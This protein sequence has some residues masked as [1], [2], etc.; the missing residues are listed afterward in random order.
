MEVARKTVEDQPQKRVADFLPLTPTNTK[1]FVE[2]FSSSITAQAMRFRLHQDLIQDVVQETLIRALRGL[3]GFRG[4]SKLSTWVYR[5]AY[6]E[7]L[8]VKERHQ[9]HQGKVASLDTTFEPV[10]SS[11]ES[12]MITGQEDEVLRVQRFMQQLPDN[13]RLAMGYH[14]MDE[15][16]VS[17]IA[18]LMGST[19]NTVK[20]WLKRGR[21]TLRELLGPTPA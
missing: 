21:E 18:E 2:E 10:S 11:Q 13:Q 12:H 16:G 15:L 1:R 9:R 5:I 8:R 20:S 19:A 6:R 14:Y 17:E 7:S 4:D 3:E